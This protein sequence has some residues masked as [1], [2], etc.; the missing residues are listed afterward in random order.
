M[1]V[2]VIGASGLIGS[3]LVNIL[4]DRGHD[5]VPASPQSGVNSVTGEGL[6]EALAGANVVVDVSNSPSFETNAVL[7]FFETSTRNL[8]DAEKAAG[9]GHHVALSVVG[10][11]RLQESGYF[12]A[13]LAQERLIRAS[14]IPYS[15]VHSTQFFEFGGGIADAATKGNTV[16]LA[17][18][19]LRP[20]AAADVAAALATVATSAPVN[21]IVEVAGPEELSLITIV[22]QALRARDD[23]RSVVSDPGA[24]YF[25]ARLETR[26]LLPGDGAQI[27]TTRFEDWVRQ[28]ANAALSHR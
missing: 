22:R 12:R 7:H 17:P 20:V 15:V 3:R 10:T 11:D 13:K 8:L 27:A 14:S 4:R 28:S 25:G 26:T 19:L 18:V 9:V 24:R 2:T 23:V 6:A 16:R 21:D 5:V 1:R